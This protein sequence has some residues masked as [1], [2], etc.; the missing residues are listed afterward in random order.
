MNQFDASVKEY[1]G[2]F[3]EGQIIDGLVNPLKYLNAKFKIAW[4]L[5]EA[6]T[7]EEKGWHIKKYYGGEN[8][9]KSFFSNTAIPTWHPIIY[10]SYGILNN[11]QD[12]ATMHYIRYKPEMCDVVSEI[13]IINANKWPSKT[14]TITLHKNLEEGFKECKPIIEH[15]VQVLKPEIHIF[16]N[17]VHLYMEIFGLNDSQPIVESDLLKVWQKDGKLFIGTYHPAIRSYKRQKY[18][19]GIINEVKKWADNRGQI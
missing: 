14:D 18:V 1:E 10:V 17:T 11:F 4:F 12:W 15:Q 16:G 9:Y 7:E 8:A 3:K 2:K 13:A 5:K 19:D 6:Y